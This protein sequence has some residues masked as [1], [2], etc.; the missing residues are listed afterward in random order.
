[1]LGDLGPRLA[2]GLVMIAF[3]LASLVAGG[4]VFLGF[5]LIA[6]LAVNWE[7]QR[8]TGGPHL[9]WRVAGSAVTIAAA[10]TFAYLG[11]GEVALVLLVLGTLLMAAVVRGPSRIWNAARIIPGTSRP[12]ARW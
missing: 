8:M 4:L 5:W 6:A 1:M 7:W 2:S 9:Q 3:A 12:C 11:Q 10:A